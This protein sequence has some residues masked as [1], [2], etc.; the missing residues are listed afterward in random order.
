MS[1][2]LSRYN[3]DWEAV[4][5]DY[6]TGRYSLSELSAMHGPARSS[7]DKRAK[8][9]GWEKDLTGAVR[10]RTREKVVRA[11][12]SPEALEAL[13]GD[14]AGIV[15]EAATLNAA[16]AA[17]H[18]KQLTAWRAIL[19]KYTTRL[20]EQLT[21]GSLT[22]QTKSG[23]VAEVDVPLDY[24]GKSLSAGTQALDRVVRMERESYGL[25]AE[26]ADQTPESRLTDDQVRARIAELEA[27]R[28]GQA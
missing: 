27:K 17:G 16:V 4:E 13:D 15:E 2:K 5:R 6:R 3:Y 10:Q 24:V 22:V 26:E 28:Q 14:D 25:D 9:H 23:D 12:L 11:A 20:D 7:I 21:R 18:R 8:T 19:D 1:K